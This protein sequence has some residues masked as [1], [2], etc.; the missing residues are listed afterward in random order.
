MRL[1]AAVTGLMVFGVLLLALWPWLLGYPPVKRPA[2][3]NLKVAARMEKQFKE[4]QVRYLA[5]SAVYISLLMVT[6]F[7]ATVCAWLLVRQA[8]REYALRSMDNLRDLIEGT[9]QDHEKRKG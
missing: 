2:P 3:G 9:L 8:R 5:R 1:K 6:F 4:E 7:S